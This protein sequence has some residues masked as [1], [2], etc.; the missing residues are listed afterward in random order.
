MK[1]SV[2]NLQFNL[3][4]CNLLNY[5]LLEQIIKMIYKRIVVLLKRKEQN[6]IILFF[7]LQLFLTWF[8]QS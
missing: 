6:C 3:Q 8:D 7:N 5:A 1:P 4:H 2:V